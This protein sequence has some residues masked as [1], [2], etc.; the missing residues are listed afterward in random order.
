MF[1]FKQSNLIVVLGHRGFGKTSLINELLEML[2]SA[3]IE[4]VILDILGKFRERSNS[5]YFNPAYKDKVNSLIR[6]LYNKH[7]YIVF[8]EADSICKPKSIPPPMYDI[9]NYG[10]NNGQGGIYS[11]RRPFRLNRDVTAGADFLILLGC[12]EQKDVEY[13]AEETNEELADRVRNL[14]KF[15]YVVYDM[16]K[17]EIIYEGVTR[18]F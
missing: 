6:K 9:L 4:F 3:Q 11:A 18:P 1:Q 17:H 7:F 14:E 10:R 5:I 8:D 2:D 16:E 13:I 15:H 12:R